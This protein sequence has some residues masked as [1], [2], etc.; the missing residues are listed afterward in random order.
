MA[1]NSCSLRAQ[2]AS[3]FWLAIFLFWSPS[4]PAR[5]HELLLIP[6]PDPPSILPIVRPGVHL[7]PEPAAVEFADTLVGSNSLAT[8]TLINV[9]AERVQAEIGESMG[10][11]RVLS[12]SCTSGTCSPTS[13]DLPA[14]ASVQLSLEFAPVEA[15]PAVDEL[16]I[17]SGHQGVAAQV[18]EI[19]SLQGEGFDG[20]R[21]EIRLPGHGVQNKYDFG[22]VSRRPYSTADLPSFTLEVH[23]TGDW[24]ATHVLIDVMAIIGI[25]GMTCSYGEAFICA[26]LE[27]GYRHTFPLIPPGEFRTVEVVLYPNE[28][29]DLVRPVRAIPSNADPDDEVA[30]LDVLAEIVPWVEVAGNG[31]L[32]VDDGSAENV[33][34]DA[35]DPFATYRPT[36]FDAK[37]L[38]AVAD[39]DSID[40]RGGNMIL[41]VPLGSFSINEGFSYGLVATYNSKIWA[42]KSIYEQCEDPDD[43]GGPIGPAAKKPYNSELPDPA[44]N[45]GMGWSLH[46]GRL[47]PPRF[48]EGVEWTYGSEWKENER[49]VLTGVYWTYISPDGSKHKFSGG[50]NDPENPH[51]GGANLS[52]REYLYARDGS[53]LRLRKVGETERHVEFPD[54]SLRVFRSDGGTVDSHRDTWRLTEIRG[55]FSRDGGGAQV[56]TITYS[57]ATWVIDDG[58]RATTIHFEGSTYSFHYPMVVDRVEFEG[59]GG[60]GTR[61]VAFAYDAATGVARPGTSQWHY[62]FHANESQVSVPLLRSITLPDVREVYSFTYDRSSGP[63]ELYMTR[64]D[65]P[66]G[67]HVVWDYDEIPDVTYADCRP[68]LEPPIERGVSRRRAYDGSQLLADTRYLREL[69]RQPE[70]LP[71]GTPQQEDLATCRSIVEPGQFYNLETPAPEM[72]VGVWKQLQSG[73]S[74]LGVQYFS[75]WPYRELSATGQ[76]WTRRENGL[77]WTR[78]SENVASQAIS[79][80]GPAGSERRLSSELYSC[81]ANVSG[82]AVDLGAFASGCDLVEAEYLG[83]ELPATDH[84]ELRGGTPCHIGARTVARETLYYTDQQSNQPRTAMVAYSDYDGLGNYRRSDSDVSFHVDPD[85]TTGTTVLS[86]YRDFNPAAGTLILNDQG[87]PA[88]DSTWQLPTAAVWILHDWDEEWIREGSGPTFGG[89]A[90]FDGGTGALLR[91]RTWAGSQAAADDLVTVYDHGAGGELIAEHHY[92]ADLGGSGGILPTGKLGT[93]GSLPSSALDYTIDRTYSHGR[94]ASEKVRG[95]TVYSVRRSV[96]PAT[97]WT[98]QDIANSGETFT[99]EYDAGGRI[100]EIDASASA[101]REY[102]YTLDGRWRFEAKAYPNGGSTVLSRYQLRYDG[103]GR[104]VDERVLRPAGG[105]SVQATSYH[106]SGLTRRISA[107]EDG[108]TAEIDYRWSDLSY[109]VKGR[110]AWRDHLDGNRTSF[111]RLGGRTVAMR[112]DVQTVNGVETSNLFREVD[113]LGRQT[114]AR[115]E[116]L[117]QT[118]TRIST[119]FVYDAQGRKV[120]AQRGQQVRRYEY[121]GRGFLLSETIPE[122]AYAT[123]FVRFDTR[124]NPLEVK[125]PFSAGNRIRLFV[126]DQLGRPVSLTVSGRLIKTWLYGATEQTPSNGQLIRGVRYNYRSAATGDG[127]VDESGRFVVTSD[128]AYDSAGRLEGRTTSTVWIPDAS[129]SAQATWSTFDQGWAYTALGQVRR[130]DYPRC[131]VGCS[132][133]ERAAHLTYSRG[134]LTGITSGALGASLQ[135][136]DNG[137][138]WKIDHGAAGID[139]YDPDPSGMGRPRKICLGGDSAGNN[140][141]LG[142]GDYQ[143]DGGGNITAIGGDSFRYDGHGRLARATLIVS[144]HTQQLDYDYDTYDNLIS[145]GTVDAA[146][147]HLIGDTDYDDFGNLTQSNGWDVHYDELDKVVLMRINTTADS[148]ESTSAS[149]D[150]AVY[151]HDDLRLLTYRS[152]GRPKWTLRDLGGGVIRELEGRL[153]DGYGL[154]QTRDHLFTGRKQLASEDFQTGAVTRYHTDHLDSARVISRPGGTDLVHYT[155][156]GDLLDGPSE[157][158]TFGFTGHENDGNGLTLNM[159]ARTYLRKLVGTYDGGRF[160]QVDPARSGWN[161]YTY[162]GGNPINRT[163]PAGL[164]EKPFEA[165]NE[166]GTSISLQGGRPVTGLI[167]MTAVRDAETGEVVDARMSLAVRAETGVGLKG[168]GD[169]SPVDVSVEPGKQKIK[170]GVGGVRVAHGND[171][172]RPGVSAKAEVR[173]KVGA[174]SVSINF[175]DGSVKFNSEKSGDLGIYLRAEVTG[176]AGMQQAVDLGDAYLKGAGIDPAKGKLPFYGTAPCPYG[177]RCQ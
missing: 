57:N 118:A 34:P 82:V 69:R 121:D 112:R 54:G 137:M 140:C 115:T 116:I 98:V 15:G 73:L 91:Q 165:E 102:T 31:T 127:L 152:G 4:G 50:L 157:G 1:S 150:A 35:N 125:E 42:R 139:R 81:T 22:V 93:L 119:T 52:G 80:R 89:E 83:F 30:Q 26:L 63:N 32:K 97:G 13:L 78:A 110:L 133:E 85:G 17:I 65:L 136:A 122:K 86:K 70:D 141:K 92:G 68:L 28:V 130:I 94:V 84:C 46:L 107:I 108:N 40:V 21:M 154:V 12:A 109:D 45:I 158:E 173:V 147:N 62:S 131:G 166:T 41:R 51:L 146:T 60:V 153:D 90:H 76:G 142:L 71:D 177:A 96:D 9:T 132:D 87:K 75:V 169:G 159:R 101:D 72:I 47:E 79:P 37:G 135:Y 145:W 162:V 3:A 151:D 29:G 64:A 105:W 100:T 10:P 19:V 126:Y 160:L 175:K 120:S 155:P 123:R 11:F 176:T 14:G 2:L 43:C 174:F 61:T 106:P 163:D 161:P 59:F 172:A 138:L 156:Y 117:G 33:D 24:D 6:S 104:V 128:L 66:A 53:H 111:S 7:R 16:A 56:V 114:L 170:V 134:F 58:I 8:L 20:P 171:P 88:D 167:T 164:Q 129:P 25:P 103:L 113:A 67:G 99:L 124:G 74:S 77:S 168:D 36:G 23:N 143:Y 18:S 27:G 55:P 144:G 49:H 95:T 44:A 39:I 38:Y 149:C 148:C 5:G 48:S